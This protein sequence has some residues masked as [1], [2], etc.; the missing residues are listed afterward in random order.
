MQSDDDD[1]RKSDDS[2]NWGDIYIYTSKWNFVI[3]F[4]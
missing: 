3:E 1:S 2:D 4:L